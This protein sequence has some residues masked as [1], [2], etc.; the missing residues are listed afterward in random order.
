MGESL[1]SLSWGHSDN[2]YTRVLNN[3]G[4][5]LST[6]YQ[7]ILGDGSETPLYLKTGKI[8]IKNAAG[9][10]TTF[11]CGGTTARDIAIID[12]DGS[13]FPENIR[14]AAANVTNVTTT[15]AAAS[16]LDFTPLANATYEF[17]AFLMVQSGSSAIAVR[18]SV[19]GPAEVTTA[20]WLSVGPY[21]VVTGETT[22]MGSG[23][24]ATYTGGFI[25]AL[26]TS[27]PVTIRGLYKTTGTPSAAI[28][29]YLNAS[30]AGTVRIMAGSY[31]RHRRIL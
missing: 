2:A 16:N 27:Y 7:V 6:G 19:D 23:L 1:A 30:A 10:V 14:F 5:P 26:N 25:P 21:N 13:L 3:S 4:I 11:T 9:Y 12:T 8:G 20:T 28:R 17:E 22:A 18:A 29:V 15:P 24:P 31:I